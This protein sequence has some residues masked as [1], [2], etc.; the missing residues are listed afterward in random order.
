MDY[1]KYVPGQSVLEAKEELENQKG[2]K[3]GEYL[4]P[5]K[6]ALE[7][8]LKQ[9]EGRGPFRYDPSSDPL[10][11]QAVDR[12]VGLGRQ[13]MMDTMGKAANL[14]GGY[15]N[16]Y[17]QTV[18]QQTYQKY[19]LCLAARL[20]QFQQMALDRYAADGKD[21][22][23]RYS[24][25]SQQDKAGFD[26]YQQAVNQYYSELNRLQNAYDRQQD[27]DRNAFTADRDFTYGKEQDAKNA[28][29]RAEQARQ[30]QIRFE[31]QQAYQRE[32][33][34]IQDQQ[35]Q[36]NFEEGRRRHEAEMAMRQAEAAAR[37]AAA[38]RSSYGRS[39]TKKEE[40]K[41]KAPFNR[42]SRDNYYNW[43]AQASRDL[44]YKNTYRSFG[45]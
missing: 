10:Y 25:L 31:L 18:G 43:R 33:D 8:I 21:M 27:R 24:V 36:Q 28:A 38:R 29:F 3:P 26:R 37:A 22:M 45:R 35:W 42:F 11:R 15:G 9:M 7:A 1:Q 40:E 5:W 6:D 12:Y 32:R 16:S 39:S 23:D 30:A 13:A 44:P 14:T 19:L 17:A 4:S 20:P 41:H 34:R 2:K